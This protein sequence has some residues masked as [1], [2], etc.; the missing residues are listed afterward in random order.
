LDFVKNKEDLKL[1]ISK[2]DNS[3]KGLN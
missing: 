1:I 2:V 3:L